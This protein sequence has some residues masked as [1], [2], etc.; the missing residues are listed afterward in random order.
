MRR[1]ISS[2]VAC[3]TLLYFATLSHKRR[4][5]LEVKKVIEHKTCVLIFYSTQLL[6][7]KFIIKKIQRDIVI[8]VKKSVCEVPVI[9]NT[10]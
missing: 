10:F 2:S 1:V 4:D 7:E 8:N 5:F 9:L 3:Q 6:A